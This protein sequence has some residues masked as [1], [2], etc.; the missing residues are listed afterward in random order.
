[1][2]NFVVDSGPPAGGFFVTCGLCAGTERG[3]F[4]MATNI[5]PR[6][7]H[8]DAAPQMLPLDTLHP[9]PKNP[10]IVLRQEI[11]DRLA[12]QMAENGFRSAHAVLVRPLDD[13]YQIIAGHHRVAAA[14]QAGLSEVPAWV[15]SLTDD[16]AYLQLVLSNEQSD[17]SPLEIGMH[18]LHYV[19]PDDKRGRGK[20]GGLGAYARTI[21]RDP[22]Y[23][24]RVRQ[25][26]E[27]FEALGESLAIW[28]DFLDKARHLAA[29]HRAPASVWLDLVNALVEFGWS[30]QETETA[31]KRVADLAAAVP[32]W[33]PFD[34]LTVAVRDASRSGAME[35]VL[36]SMAE[37]ADDLPESITL[38]D[39]APT[40]ETDQRDGR[41]YRR[42]DAVPAE[43]APRQIFQ[44]AVLSQPELP[45]ADALRRTQKDI[46]ERIHTQSDNAPRYLPTRTDAEESEAQARQ[47]QLE[48][49]QIREAYMP[50]VIQSTW[51][52][53]LPTLRSGTFDLVAIDPP[54]GMNKAEWDP[55]LDPLPYGEWAEPWLR[56]SFRL[57]KDTGNLFVFGREPQIAAAMLMAIKQGFRFRSY[58]M[59]ETVQGAKGGMFQ[60]QAEHI[61]WLSK[62][63]TPYTD[64]DAVKVERSEENVRAFR[65][66]E[67]HYTSIGPIW[68]IPAIS[69]AGTERVGHPTQK[70]IAVMTRIITSA[71]PLDGQVLDFFGGSG[72]T[73]I[74]AMQSRRHAV[75][76]E[77]SPE[78]VDIIHR[79]VETAEVGGDDAP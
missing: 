21:Q 1:M 17:L 37:L 66:Q 12:A 23:I 25:A 10:R 67:Y 62:T 39:Y 64:P 79:R 14:R 55:T 75:L 57:L 31:S 15:E 20:E 35:R 61:I 73:G 6:L 60:G 76:I 56:E 51:E 4:D 63:Q 9:H 50:K 70:P 36:R 28:Q 43:F 2:L 27:V 24:T 8:R 5:V 40:D 68:R 52:S 47:Q 78:Y 42:W 16:E 74:A 48:Q 38:Y 32:S 30:V 26:A 13:G 44:D 46:L 45:S 33:Y 65:G 49:M 54:Y 53:Q 72:T 77:Q 29:I 34:G 22:S 3:D 41:E 59:W 7:E 11:I 69:S 19:A 58:I 18:A 71:C